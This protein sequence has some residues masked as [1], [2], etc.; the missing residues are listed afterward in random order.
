MYMYMTLRIRTDLSLP[1]ALLE[2]VV[3]FI[4]HLLQ[5]DLVEQRDALVRVHADE[6]VG[7]V[8]VDRFLKR[9]M[10][11]RFYENATCEEPHV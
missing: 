3:G 10:Y 5:G 9:R 1:V 2:L 8:R 4:L 6:H 11:I 7:N